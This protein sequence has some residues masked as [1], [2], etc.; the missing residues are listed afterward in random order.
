MND[1]A[2]R[3]R[4][5]ELSNS[6][7]YLQYV[8]KNYIKKKL[9]ITPGCNKPY[10]ESN[11][12]L[13]KCRSAVKCICY[14]IYIKIQQTAA[15]VTRILEVPQ[16]MATCSTTTSVERD[17]IHQHVTSFCGTCQW[18]LDMAPNV[19][20]SVFRADWWETGSALVGKMAIALW[21]LRFSYLFGKRKVSCL[22]PAPI[23]KHLSTF[24]CICSQLLLKPHLA[25]EVPL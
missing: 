22:F 11:F 20:L 18:Q 5:V 3:K 17:T 19:P 8:F 24:Y 1:Y 15:C 14:T 6:T 21:V 2:N 4:F 13:I 7:V 9:F 10:V 16:H 25:S 23:S 12:L